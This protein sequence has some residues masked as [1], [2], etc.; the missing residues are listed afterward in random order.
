MSRPAF[1]WHR[2][3]ILSC[4]VWMI[5]MVLP[6][7]AQAQ[8]KEDDA[9]KAGISARGDKKWP[10]VALQMRRAIE[11]NPQ[12]ATRRVRSG[13][14]GSIG[15][16]FGQ[17][18]T[19]YLP[20]FFLGEAL[21][22]LEDCVGAVGAWSN[23]ERQGAIRSTA[24]LATLQKGYAT[25]E[26]KGVL[27]PDK[28]EQSLRQTNEQI[29]DASN[30]ATRV[31]NLDTPNG[32][33]RQGDKREQYTRASGE[34]ESARAHL[35][36]ATTLRSRDE[37][38]EASAAAERAKSIL[39]TLETSLNAA[40]AARRTVQGQVTDV[41]RL[42]SIAEGYDRDIAAKNSAL[43]LPLV[44]TR[45]EG[46]VALTRARD[47]LSAGTKASDMSAMSDA[48]TS[49][50]LASTRLKEVLDELMKLEKDAQQRQLNQAV[51]RAQEAFSLVDGASARLHDLAAEKPTLM[52]PDMDAKQDAIRRQV[53]KARGQFNA[54][55][56]AE[57]LPSINEATRLITEARNLLNELISTFV[58]LTITERGVPQTLVSGYGRF[59]A[60]EY[61]QVLSVLNPGD[62]PADSRWQ[63][64]VHLF[65][66]A[67]LFAL[68]V[69]P[70]E[71]D[72]SLGEQALNEVEQC[73]QIDPSFTP[74]PQVFSP[75]FISFF[76]DGRVVRTERG[77][78]TSSRQ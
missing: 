32:D 55:R 31:V 76:H 53:A 14:A 61:Q 65:R 34:I 54:A 50:T 60:G 38:N 6:W 21:L 15:G 51:A 35:V 40:I 1:Q 4:A 9:F 39:V 37:F 69:Q 73:K 67:A 52:P 18:G 59:V 25:C 68:S 62:L 70:R 45:Q 24:F 75:R 29:T 33:L 42:I 16:L 30:Q 46:T 48:R 12:E 26:A 47:R 58:P 8:D 64:Q 13:I 43:P 78:T 66:A 71:V 27:P 56:N 11:V 49:A 44:A 20:Y 28:Y 7:A 5:T 41:Q 3:M 17:G 19:E 23:S 22:N 72:Q 36:T 10:D 77:V 2:L 63:L 74:D 57:N